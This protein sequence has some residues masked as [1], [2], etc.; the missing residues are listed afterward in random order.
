MSM[1]YFDTFVIN[2]FLFVRNGSKGE[3]K[4]KK[5][6]QRKSLCRPRAAYFC[7]VV[8][9]KG[10]LTRDFLLQVFFMNRLSPGP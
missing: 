3:K 1:E 7:T 8:V 9:L 10:S 2:S 5:S 6:Q 4:L